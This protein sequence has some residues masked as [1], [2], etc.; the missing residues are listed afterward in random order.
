MQLIISLLSLYLGRISDPSL[1]KMIG[2]ISMRLVSMA[3]IHEEF[4][5]SDDL[6]RIDFR[7]YLRQ[8][9][10]SLRA[11]FPRFDGSLSV[12]ADS[13]RAFLRLEKA[14]P[15]GLAAT[16]LLVNAIRFAYPGEAAPGPI[17]VS[18]RREGDLYALV[19][20]DDGV[21]IGGSPAEAGDG[22]GITLVRSFSAQ[23]RGELELRDLGGAEA[24]LR[25][26]A[27]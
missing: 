7:A 9:V 15:A 25:F 21:G 3:S 6:S 24:V 23:L 26:P 20:K 2:D 12:S 10:A 8:L 16:E 18:I 22:L 5:N 11:E 27:D 13:G 14:L 19:V 4:Y 17:V 1:Q